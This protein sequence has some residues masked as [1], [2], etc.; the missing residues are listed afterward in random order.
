MRPIFE[1]L[2]QWGLEM[3][4]T[5]GEVIPYN[6]QFHQLLEGGGNAEV[7]EP[8]IIRYVGYDHDHKLLYRPKVSPVKKDEETTTTTN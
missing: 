2:K 8:V 1:L 4:G 5:V 6:P 3:K 7:G